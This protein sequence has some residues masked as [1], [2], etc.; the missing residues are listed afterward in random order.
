[1]Q[2]RLVGMY[3]GETRHGADGAPLPATMWRGIE[4]SGHWSGDVRNQRADGSLY[5][6]RLSIT[7]VRDVNQRVRYFVAVFSDTS[8][9]EASRRRLEHVATHDALTGVVGGNMLKP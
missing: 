6:E 7:A 9:A 4:K 5:S 1:A 8:V 2:E 3:L